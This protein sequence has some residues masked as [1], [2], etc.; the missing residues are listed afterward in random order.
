M[1]KLCKIIS[2]RKAAILLLMVCVALLQTG[3][4]PK[5]AAAKA[6]NADKPRKSVSQIQKEALNR[7]RGRDVPWQFY[8]KYADTFKKLAESVPDY[9]GK[10]GAQAKR[11]RDWEKY[12]RKFSELIRGMAKSRRTIDTILQHQ[13]NMQKEKRSRLLKRARQQH[14]KLLQQALKLSHNPPN[15]P[16]SNFRRR[17]GL[18]Q[19]PEKPKGRRRR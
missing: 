13:A 3:G 15:Q 7:I 9:R 1:K 11:L 16:P 8:E 6:P 2:D 10:T 14:D 17:G 19:V 18:L 4:S 12:Y 5:S